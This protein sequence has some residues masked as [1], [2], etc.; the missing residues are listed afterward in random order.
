MIRSFKTLAGLVLAATTFG[1]VATLESKATPSW[2][3]ESSAEELYAQD[4]SLVFKEPCVPQFSVDFQLP[5]RVIVV[6]Q[7][8]NCPVSTQ[9]YVKLA[10]AKRE[11]RLIAHQSQ[12]YSGRWVTQVNPV[13]QGG[14]Y[15]VMG[16]E[17]LNGKMSPPLDQRI[18]IPVAQQEQSAPEPT[19]F[20]QQP[21][22]QESR[23][24]SSQSHRNG[25]KTI[26][27]VA[28][29]ISSKL[30]RITWNGWETDFNLLFRSIKECFST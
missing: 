22:R 10:D 21:L 2:E 25:Q 12:N 27:D 28:Q 16:V 30:G 4:P 6:D 29:C 15:R 1:V 19:V 14:L 18:T 26:L 20:L 24:E 5:E 3:R 8:D 13:A 9:V 11:L 17:Y 7:Q 23:T